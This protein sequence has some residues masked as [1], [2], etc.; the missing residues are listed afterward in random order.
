MKLNSS[1]CCLKRIRLTFNKN[2]LLKFTVDEN[3][4]RLRPREQLLGWN[5]F[6]KYRKHIVDCR[7]YLKICSLFVDLLYW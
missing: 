2:P 4:N 7:F 3:H 5:K 1:F 6:T